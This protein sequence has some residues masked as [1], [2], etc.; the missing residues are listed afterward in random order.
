MNSFIP[1]V[2]GKGKLLWIINKMAPERYS[3]FIDVFGGSGTVTMNRPTRKGCM[4]VYNDFNGNLTNLFCCVKNRTL[5]LLSELGFLPLNTRDDFNVLYKFFSRGEFT[6]DYLQE[7]MNLTEV[8][9]KPPDAEAIRALM[10]ERAP[11]G[12]I[13]RAADYFKLVRY[14]FSGSAKSFG[15]KPCDIRRFFHLIWECSRRLANVIVENKDFEDVI[16]QYDRED[17]WIYCD[18]PYFEAECYEVGF[19]KADHQRLHDT[20]LN[21]RGYAAQIR[22]YKKYIGARDDWELVD[23]FADEG[24]TGMKSETRDEFQRM[25][26]MCELKQIDLI[27]TKSISRFARNTKDALAYVRK[28]KLLG[29]GV[30]FE[31]EGISTLSMG[32]EMLLNTFSALAQEESQSISMNQRLSIVKRMELGEYVDSN[33]PYGY[34]LV[35][36]MLTVYEP[37]AGIVRNIFAL[38]LQGFSTSEIAKELNKLNIPTKA[39]KE[40]WRPSRV[41]Y[42]LKNERYIGDSF[43]Q[44]TYRETTVPF[45]Q[46]PNRGQEDRFYA[47]GT[48]PGIVEKDVFD[49]AQTLIEKRKDVFAKA[50]TQNIYPLTSRIQCSECGSFYRRRIV[51]GTV[52]WVCSLHKDDSTACDSNY[53]NEERIYDGFISL[54]NKLRFS[55]DNILGQVIS[56]LEMTL[57][58]MK[59][60]NLAAR[61]LSKSIAELNAKLLMLEQLRSKGYLAPEVYQAQANEIS[62]ELAKL[63][64]VRQEKFNSKAAIM[65]EEVKKLKMLIFELEEPLDAFD[66]KLFLEIVKSI[67]I[68]KEDEMSVELLGGLRFRERI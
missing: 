20:L 65:F 25:I 63:K 44:K 18:P 24:L 16:R 12:D 13:R 27:I 61:D 14:S 50:T 38:Y 8:Y 47:K 66:E 4:E 59:R 1:W 54:V 35:D 48:H 57:A 15:G 39:G 34:R 42:I 55:E 9:L 36:K 28:L 41:A 45:N 31:K 22:A 32:D 51:S 7:E 10:L 2:G 11:R 17:A 56:R 67:Q 68:N 26:R 3:R 62:A 30:Q 37:E 58:A 53:Y 33:A 46:H 49:A 43:Y 29:V 60:N 52:K 5:A 19:P 64:D 40:T 6:D 23:I 21:C